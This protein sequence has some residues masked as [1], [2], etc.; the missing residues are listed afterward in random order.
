MRHTI[1]R[2][3]VKEAYDNRAQAHYWEGVNRRSTKAPPRKAWDRLLQG[4]PEDVADKV[5]DLWSKGKSVQRPRIN[6]ENVN[7]HNFIRDHFEANPGRLGRPS[8]L[9]REFVGG[10]MFTGS[11]AGGGGDPITPNEVRG[12]STRK[13]DALLDSRQT[14]REIKAGRKRVGAAR[15]DAL[16]AEAALT[17]VRVEDAMDR[18]RAA[19][20]GDSPYRPAPTHVAPAPDPGSVRTTPGQRPPMPTPREATPATARRGLLGRLVERLSPLSS[21]DFDISEA[22]PTSA[23]AAS[24]PSPSAPPPPSVPTPS[25]APAASAPSTP[26]RLPPKN[27]TESEKALRQQRLVAV[28]AKRRRDQKARAARSAAPAPS[29]STTPSSTAPSSSTTPSSSAPR[30]ST[31]PSSTAPSSSTT[32]SSSAPR[33]STTP[34]STAPS[35][36]TTPS[37]TT[38]RPSASP[39]STASKPNSAPASAPKLNPAVVDDAVLESID[40]SRKVGK[41]ARSGSGRIPLA[42]GLATLGLGGYA[43]LRSHRRDGKKR[44]MREKRSFVERD[45]AGYLNAE[46]YSGPAAELLLEL[47][48]GQDK[49]ASGLNYVIPTALGLGSAGTAA[50]VGMREAKSN[51]KL[52]VVKNIDDRD[53][54]RIAEASVDAQEYRRA[55]PAT[56]GAGL[57]A[58]YLTGQHLSADQYAKG[59][60]GL[61]DYGVRGKILH[62]PGTVFQSGMKALG[63]SAAQAKGLAGAGILAAG[64]YGGR[65]MG[66]RMATRAYEDAGVKIGKDGKMQK[67]AG[68]FMRPS[69]VAGDHRDL[70]AALEGRLN[71]T[72]QRDFRK[73]ADISPLVST[74]IGAAIGLAYEPLRQTLSKP[75]PE[76]PPLAPKSGLMQR[77]SYRADKRLSDNDRW[78]REHPVTSALISGA[79]GAAAGAVVGFGTAPSAVFKS[80]RGK[81]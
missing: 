49:T 29:P 18:V 8:E 39:S 47:T 25:A 35:S 74:G 72:G 31:S 26:P 6:G 48:Q 69:D 75:S 51:A 21:G 68:L 52:Q 65:A 56:I 5:K 55:L 45:M 11:A 76:P 37:S 44:S 54:R 1:N 27:L 32:P 64:Y 33:P 58:M 30:S 23:P 67:S 46:D 59:L 2:Q 7:V 81:I 9:S 80:L 42:L 10:S 16:R 3:L 79:A 60:K 22:R 34:S 13:A 70:S 43:A 61:K 38:S 17:Q 71:G 12:G 50:V 78:R 66:D 20:I 53:K 41:G 14:R 57:G 36:S 77:L 19:D 24:T 15:R 28:L 63:A 40:A 73:E 4:V 62:G